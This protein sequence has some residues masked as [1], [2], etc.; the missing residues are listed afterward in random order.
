MG[1]PFPPF[2]HLPPPSAL[3]PPICGPPIFS[4]YSAPS[5][6]HGV[7]EDS[8]YSQINLL[9]PSS[10]YSVEDIDPFD[11]I[12]QFQDPATDRRSSSD[13]V[14]ST[15]PLSRSRLQQAPIVQPS[16]P[17]NSGMEYSNRLL[18]ITLAVHVPAVSAALLSPLLHN[19]R[20]TPTHPHAR[21]PSRSPS[22]PPLKRSTS[23]PTATSTPAPPRSNRCRPRHRLPHTA[24]ERRYRENLNAHL[25]ALRAAVPSLQPGQ[26]ARRRNVGDT[27]AAEDEPKISK[28]EI[29]MGAVEYIGQLEK[30][31]KC[32]W[33]LE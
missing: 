16:R 31:R 18:P 9:T 15:E 24:V 32:G 12:P 3:Y 13:P 33:C 10:C 11:R 6:P 4:A 29:L 20:L 30:E 8:P 28:C 14:Q 25:Q 2:E 22:R 21:D 17:A 27:D 23:S 26:Q 1:Q 7:L 19:Q 5:Y